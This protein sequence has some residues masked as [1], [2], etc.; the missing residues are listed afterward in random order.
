MKDE[1]EDKDL[2]QLF[3]HRLQDSENLF[4]YNEED[5][6]AM[7]A[8][9]DKKESRSIAMYWLRI[10]SGI[11]AMLLLCF[12][13]WFFTQTKPGDQ[14]VATKK[15]KTTE[16]KTPVEVPV[17]TKIT[18]QVAKEELKLSPSKNLATVNSHQVFAPIE[19][20][21]AVD[22]VVSQQT[23]Q[24]VPQQ[25]QNIP[26]VDS[27]KVVIAANT[28]IVQPVNQES[29]IVPIN[30]VAVNNA[31]KIDPDVVPI[32][33]IKKD[34]PVA[35]KTK[36]QPLTFAV[37]IVAAPDLNGIDALKQTKVGTNI[38]ALLNVGISKKLTLQT[39]LIYS[40]KPYQSNSASYTATYTSPYAAKYNPISVYVECKMFDVPL[41]LDYQV[42]ENRANKISLGTGVSSYIMLHENY[43]YNFDPAS[44][45]STKYYE[46]PNSKAYMFS[47]LNL[48]AT[49]ERKINNRFGL[50]AQPYLKVPLRSVGYGDVKLQ[51]AGMAIGLKMNFNKPKSR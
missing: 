31:E 39:G 21:K 4:A 49:Y 27:G 18:N 14:A 29:V 17:V 38:G 7:E 28:P 37:S 8:K 30:T 15:T 51:S 3:K 23:L 45:Y 41:N 46:V 5:W 1:E 35:L 43:E 2:D 6:L 26:S 22:Q 10:G 24:A 16:K 13:W 48:S 47:I 40:D 9:L 33:P 11:A 12:G 42:F 44:Y 19:K 20:G 34:S 25:V 36:K 32:E 50:T